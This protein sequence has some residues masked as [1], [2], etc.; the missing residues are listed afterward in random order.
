MLGQLVY[1]A[2]RAR[3]AIEGLLQQLQDHSWGKVPGHDIDLYSP[4]FGNLRP[5][6]VLL[7]G[8]FYYMYR[9]QIDK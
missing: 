1:L 4:S 6:R 2:H 5:E 7:C 9:A 8:M 3:I